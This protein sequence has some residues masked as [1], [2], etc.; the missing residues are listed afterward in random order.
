VATIFIFRLRTLFIGRT[1]LVDCVVCEV[2]EVV[3]DVASCRLLVGLSA[4]TSQALF[5]DVHSQWIH[6]V[7][8][9]IDPQ[10]ILQ[11]VNQVWA[12]EVV[13]DD[14]TSDSIF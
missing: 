1:E 10:I 5:V 13:L 2:H 14:P 6:A 3:V 12:V 7:Y 8:E 9:H 4:K 11:V